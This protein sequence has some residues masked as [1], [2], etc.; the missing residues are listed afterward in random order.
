MSVAFRLL[1][2][3]VT[4]A[5]LS[6]PQAPERAGP[7]FEIYSDVALSPYP[8]ARWCILLERLEDAVA[9]CV[10]LGQ[11]MPRVASFG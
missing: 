9:G 3:E 10:E 8:E 2:E 7:S 6:D 4:L 5:P 1:A 11:S